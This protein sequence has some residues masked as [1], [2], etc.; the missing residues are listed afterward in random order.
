MTVGSIA[1]F[2]IGGLFTGLYANGVRRLPYFR[3]PGVVL[4]CT[5]AGFG[6]GYWFHKYEDENPA[7][8]FDLLAL[9]EKTLLQTDNTD[10]SE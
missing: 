8:G 7:E 2:T 5:A 9:R 3:N 10:D 1:Y 4:G 6:L